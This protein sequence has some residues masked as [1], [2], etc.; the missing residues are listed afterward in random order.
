MII[1]FS[2]LP[3]SGKTTTVKALMKSLEDK[4]YEC[5]EP[6]R[7]KRFFRYLDY[8]R[9]DNLKLRYFLFLFSKK[10]IH[11]KDFI[12]FSNWFL[13]FYN[14]Y[15][16]NNTISNNRIILV[17]QGLLQLL[18]SISFTK[19]MTD[20]NDIKN[21]LH[22]INKKGVVFSIIYCFSD[23]ETVYYRLRERGISG[24]RIDS[25]DEASMKDALR[26]QE[27]NFSLLYDC[28]KS[29]FDSVLILDAKETIINKTNDIISYL[30]I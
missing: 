10:Y 19:R 20:S 22:Y 24:R 2:G 9:F 15:K 1:E 21:I 4:G 5:I 7:K 3:G 28:T 11:F 23:I 26:I 29:E 16:S 12:Y 13:D 6:V 18:I 27:Q 30:N 8:F 14:Y 17:E 25:M